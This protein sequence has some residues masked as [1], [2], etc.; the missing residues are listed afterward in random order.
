MKQQQTKIK[1]GLTGYNSEICKKFLNIYKNKYQ[2]YNYK[3]NINNIK[4]TKKWLKKNNKINVLINFAA[5]VSKEKCF[6]NKRLAL[7]TNCESVLNIAKIL[8]NKQFK[9]FQ[10]LMLL[11]TS[12]VFS[13]TNKILKENSKKKPTNYY[14]LTKLQME[15]EFKKKKFFF[16]IGIGRIF[17]YYYNSKKKGYFI[18]DVIRKM[19][20]KK[21]T[22]IFKGVDT[23]RDYIHIKDICSAI[24]HMITKKLKGD[25]NIC[26]G[27]GLELKRIIK[28][29]NIK[30]KKNLN[31]IDT[32]QKGLVGD[33][34]KL[35]KT[36]WKVL[37]KINY[38]NII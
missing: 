22:L 11:S 17:N 13:F 4:Q 26:S 10:Y 19:K 12:H 37:K 7:K 27:K 25:Y 1:I 34:S 35:K 31:F 33:N 32:H 20:L 29:I 2:F 23:I 15:N 6:K 21:N 14:G 8:N 24:D 28:K 5:I 9:E 3:G 18:N 36:G 16:R 30:Y 38:E